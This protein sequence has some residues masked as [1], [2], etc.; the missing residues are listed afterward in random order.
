MLAER[1]R[2][3]ISKGYEID[4]LEEVLQEVIV[5]SELKSLSVE[6]INS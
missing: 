2:W 5:E 3:N 6:L 4:E 1:E